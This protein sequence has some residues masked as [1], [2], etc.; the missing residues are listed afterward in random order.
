MT[1]TKKKYICVIFNEPIIDSV[2]CLI[3]LVKK[4]E[5]NNFFVDIFC[6]GTRNLLYQN[7]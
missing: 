7:P 5:Q 2:P 4:L 1:K 6:L 3:S